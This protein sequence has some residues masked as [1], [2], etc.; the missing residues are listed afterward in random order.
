MLAILAR[1][2]PTIICQNN[3]GMIILEH[4]IN[5]NTATL[6]LHKVIGTHHQTDHIGNTYQLYL[7]GDTSAQI[8]LP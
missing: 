8:L 4:D 6:I 7:C 5:V 2:S 3:S 1:Q